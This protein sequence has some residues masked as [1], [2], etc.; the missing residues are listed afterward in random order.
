[1]LIHIFRKAKHTF[2]RHI[3]SELTKSM[4]GAN[5]VATELWIFMFGLMN[6]YV[7]SDIFMGLG[8]LFT[9][10]IMVN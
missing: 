9:L 7:L 1:M 5:Q 2:Q 4:G 3:W 10:Q 6:I 8:V